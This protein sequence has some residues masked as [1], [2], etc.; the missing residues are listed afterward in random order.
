MKARVQMKTESRIAPPAARLI[1]LN[2]SADGSS[3]VLSA[4]DGTSGVEKFE[5]KFPLSRENEV[6]VS[7]IRR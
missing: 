3:A 2:Q 5:L 4:W 6:N 7:E 1:L